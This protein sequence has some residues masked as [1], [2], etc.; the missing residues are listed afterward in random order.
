MGIFNITSSN[1]ESLKIDYGKI[2][3]I[4][5]SETINLTSSAQIKLPIKGDSE[6]MPYYAKINVSFIGKD[7]KESYFDMVY[8]CEIKKMEK[9][10]LSEEDTKNKLQHLVKEE[11]YPKVKNYIDEFYKISNID[12]IPLPPIDE[13][14]KD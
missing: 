3:Q 5:A 11:I 14:S 6:D 12:F 1:V 13:D 8:V 10:G 7:G 9:V 4:D 2:K